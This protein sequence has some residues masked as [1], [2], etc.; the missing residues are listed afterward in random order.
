MV[1]DGCTIS[2]VDS[3]MISNFDS[4]MNKSLHH[5][6]LSFPSS[7]WVWYDGKG[8]KPYIHPC[9]QTGH[10]CWQDQCLWNTVS[11]PLWLRHDAEDW[12]RDL[13]KMSGIHPQ[14]ARFPGLCP[15]N[16]C[17]EKQQC[18]G[19]Y[20]ELQSECA[21]TWHSLGARSLCQ[22]MDVHRKHQGSCTAGDWS[23]QCRIQSDREVLDWRKD[24][25]SANTFHF[26]E[27]H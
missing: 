9:W 23:T 13:R 11:G 7:C 5:S 2:S 20:Q 12:K 27:N 24:W 8:G 15:D 6:D 4:G 14:L 17:L 3:E 10:F 26:V 16:C 21:T 22:K 25:L 19:A 18:P 1:M